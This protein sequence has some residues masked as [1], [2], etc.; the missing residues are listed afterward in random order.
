VPTATESTIGGYFHGGATDAIGINAAQVQ[1]S[2][3]NAA[4]QTENGDKVGGRLVKTGLDAMEVTFDIFSEST[5]HNPYVV[6]MTRFHPKNS[7]PGAVQNLVYAEA[8]NPIDRKPL[9]VHLLEG[10]FPFDFE[11]LDFQVHI[12]DRGIEIATNIATNR[13]ELTR[14]EAFDYV[15]FEYIGAHS[16]DTLPAAPAM[17]KLPADLPTR[18]ATGKYT[19]TYYVRV[20]KDGIGVDIFY[21]PECTKRV[22]DD[23]LQGVARDIRFKPALE[24]GRPVDGVAVVRLGQLAI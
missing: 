16:K 3:N 11:V 12:Y 15:K 21:D 18:L 20:N 4:A 10:G 23:Y 7:K 24:K 14:D 22:R 6:T 17:G 1:I 13:V 2:A 5:L 9:H 8:L 19:A